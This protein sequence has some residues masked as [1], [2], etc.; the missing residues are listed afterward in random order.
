[1]NCVI[2]LTS[3]DADSALFCLALVC[4]VC[5][6][7]LLDHGRERCVVCGSRFTPS[8]VVKACLLGLD[9][10]AGQ[11][12]KAYI[13]LAVA[14][15]SAGDPRCALRSLAIAQHLA[16]SGSR[17]ELL[18]KI[19]TAQSLL[20][21]GHVDDADASLRGVMPMILEM[22]RTFGN[23]ILFASCCTLLC[24]TSM[25]QTKLGA[26][27]AWLRRALDIQADLGLNASL[28]TS[29]ELD[30]KILSRQGKYALAKK[31]L[32]TAEDIMSEAE[33]D[34]VL[35]GSVQMQFANAEIHF[36]EHRP[37]RSRPL[38]HC[39]LCVVSHRDPFAQNSQKDVD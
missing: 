5:L 31:T 25:Q 2:C 18:I 28:A 20:A 3:P 24:K 33:S 12:P 34:E 39:C 1:M 4:R 13:Q 17:W 23:G 38:A 26:A 30:A 36:G 11:D 8:A 10:S 32:Q 14:H 29:L 16:V 22:P 19:E 35:K 9:G 21:I 6:L 7:S 15:S 27:R 37:F